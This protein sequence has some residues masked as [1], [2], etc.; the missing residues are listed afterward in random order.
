MKEESERKRSSV[1]LSRKSFAKSYVA[2]VQDSCVACKGMHPLHKCKDFC[3][4]PHKKKMTIVKGN[5]L[6]LNCLRSGHFLRNCPS[7]QRCKECRKP[8][9][10]LLHIATPP[11]RETELLRDKSPPKEKPAIISTHVSQLKNCRQILLMTCC[12]KI[13]GPDGSTTQARALLDS[14]SS[15]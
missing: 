7:E 11:K 1:P 3:T 12:V 14:A 8:H 9:H 6:C 10:S 13:V 4:M 15:A 5:T 2:A